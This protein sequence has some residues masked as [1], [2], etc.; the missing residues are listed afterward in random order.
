MEGLAMNEAILDVLILYLRKQLSQASSES[1]VWLNV[2]RYIDIHFR[3]GANGRPK[4]HFDTNA[5]W[6]TSEF[7]WGLLQEHGCGVICKSM[8]D[9]NQLHHWKVLP[10]HVWWPH[11]N[12]VLVSCFQLTSYPLCDLAAPKT[13]CGWQSREGTSWNHGRGSTF[14]LFQF[15]LPLCSREC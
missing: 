13:T 3:E 1:V 14:S 6:W 8:D 5:S 4:E 2:N 15:Y 10:H 7:N 9:S 12:C 11:R